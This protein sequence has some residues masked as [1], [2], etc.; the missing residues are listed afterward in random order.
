MPLVYDVK[1]NGVS[2]GIEPG[3]LDITEVLKQRS[4]CGFRVPDKTRSFNFQIGAPVQVLDASLNVLF[5]GT[6]DQ[7]EWK[8]RSGTT[9]KFWDISCID[10]NQL[11][12]KRHVQSATWTNK[13]L[14]YIVR[15]IVLIWLNGEGINVT[16]VQDGPTLPTFTVAYETVSEAFTALA[17]RAA[18]QTGVAWQWKIFYDKALR[19]FSP[20]T[21]T[22]PV[23]LTGANCRADT[24]R[25]RWTR[26]DYWNRVVVWNRSQDTIAWAD[27]TTEQLARIAIEG[28]SGVYERVVILDDSTG[29]D[30]MQE[31]AL[32][33]LSRT[34]L[35]SLVINLET[36]EQG[37]QVGQN[38]TL[39]IDGYGTSTEESQPE[40]IDIEDG[41]EFVANQ[42]IEGFPFDDFQY[43][44]RTIR[45]YDEQGLALFRQ[46]EGIG[47]P[48]TR[49]YVDWFREL[50]KGSASSSGGDAA[51]DL[52][53]TI[54]G[55]AVTF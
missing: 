40:G 33:E 18:D 2:I 16:G 36:R 37:L 13:S 29:I 42:A 11:P 34:K 7:P 23:A 14:G 46:V 44:I 24:I 41:L 15:D 26:E 5:G 35:M 51:I 4:T 55:V 6:I 50:R 53:V 54:G 39:D 38:F 12:D 32:A 9:A 10:W 45:T 43:L 1:V 49:D 30:E 20:D 17:N 8:I 19:F 48:V 3:T 31:I 27:D 21:Y 52:G 47:G 25:A 28:G 22:A